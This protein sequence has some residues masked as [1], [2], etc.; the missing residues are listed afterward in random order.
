MT[1]RWGI[2]FLLIATSIESLGFSLPI[3]LDQS[4]RREIVRTLGFGS[5]YRSIAEPYP[6][7]GYQGIDIGVSY[8]TIP[9]GHFGSY[10]TSPS[11]VGHEK[12]LVLSR[13]TV[14]KGLFNNVDVYLS[15]LPLRQATTMSGY[16]GLIRWNFYEAPLLPL[17]VSAIVHVSTQNIDNQISTQS[18]GLDIL[19]GLT[20]DMF[21]VYLGV[22]HLTAL[23][24][25]TP[26]SVGGVVQSERVS[27]IR[28]YIGGTFKI[29]PGFIGAQLDQTHLPMWGLRAGLRF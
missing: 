21:S 28:T 18:Q 25:F 8:E 19:S 1:M 13:L 27:I 26:S 20:F 7:G 4:E 23:G 12:D 2:F 9:I 17:T 6:L 11:S 14:G 29:G 24:E 22:G 5:S 16:G 10:G 15:I 3:G